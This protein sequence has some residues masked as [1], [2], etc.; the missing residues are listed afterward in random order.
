[1][2]TI[3]SIASCVLACTVDAHD[4]V[5]GLD[6][7]NIVG[8]PAWSSIHFFEYQTFVVIIIARF[9]CLIFLARSLAR[10]LYFYLKTRTRQADLS[11]Y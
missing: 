4:A 5:A 10:K 9:D 11:F 3:I 6:S 2:R 8:R 1:M 7:Q